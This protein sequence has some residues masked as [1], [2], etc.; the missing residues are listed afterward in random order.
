MI[1]ALLKRPLVVTDTELFKVARQLCRR[2]YRIGLLGYR[3]SLAACK[4]LG[5]SVLYSEDLTHGRDYGGS[6]GG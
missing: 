4:R 6:Q 2:R 1:E 5:A 3:C